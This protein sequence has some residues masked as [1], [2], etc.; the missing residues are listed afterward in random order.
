VVLEALAVL[1]E[2]LA[3]L[4]ELVGLFAVHNRVDSGLAEQALGVDG[5]VRHFV[6]NNRVIL[7]FE[8]TLFLRG[9]LN[10][11]YYEIEGLYTKNRGS[12]GPLEA[13]CICS[14]LF[15]FIIKLN[16]VSTRITGG[17]KARGTRE[18]EDALVLSPTP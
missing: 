1:A 4:A 8:G 17:G 7:L 10:Q 6:L 13:L 18:T 15:N 16:R 11:F 2:A 12:G 3:E 5:A 14:A 9:P